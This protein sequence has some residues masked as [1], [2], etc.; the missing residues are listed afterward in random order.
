MRTFAA[1]LVSTS[2]LIAVSA[3]DHLLVLG[4]RVGPFRYH[5]AHDGQSDYRVARTLFGRPTSRRVDANLCRITWRAA[6]ISI[7]FAS[8]RHPC[9]P[10]TLAAH[11]LWYGMTLWGPAW[12]T[13]RGLHV[14]MSVQAV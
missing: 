7:G 14:G 8:D 6:G 12:H 5:S 4:K 3:N 2:A 13:T 10:R 11:G 9:A 1:V